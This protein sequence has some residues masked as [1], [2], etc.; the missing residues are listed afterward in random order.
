M[1]EENKELANKLSQQ[2]RESLK[3]KQ[4][5][6]KLKRTFISKIKIGILIIL[7]IIII[8]KPIET[9]HLVGQFIADFFG[10]ILEPIIIKSKNIF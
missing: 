2:Y 7:G 5:T 9:G 10:S 6:E 3:K 4:N 1:L 8:L